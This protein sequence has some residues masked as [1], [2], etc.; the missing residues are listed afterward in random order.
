MLVNFEYT[1]NNA[2]ANGDGML[3]KTEFYD[4]LNR[5]EGVKLSTK[6]KETIYT[7]ADIDEDGYIRLDEFFSFLKTYEIPGSVN[8]S[9]ND[10]SKDQ[11]SPLKMKRSSS[12]KKTRQMTRALS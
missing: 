11:M 6:E 4:A 10:E 5:L 12:K 7:L 9:R 3:N 1:F 8:E 2:D